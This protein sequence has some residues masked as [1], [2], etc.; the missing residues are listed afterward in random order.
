MTD[1]DAMYAHAINSHNDWISQMQRGIQ[2]R[3]K[4][5]E[6]GESPP[7]TDWNAMKQHVTDSHEEWKEQ[8]Q[9]QKRAR[10]ESQRLEEEGEEDPGSEEEV[11]PEVEVVK[12]SPKRTRPYLP[13]KCKVNWIL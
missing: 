13:R 6:R 3:R 2:E 1:W 9:E 7:S 5:R 12:S 4:M 8:Y 10:W 11:E